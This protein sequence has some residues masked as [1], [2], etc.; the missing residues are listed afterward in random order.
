MNIEEIKQN[1]SV[2]M[3]KEENLGRCYN[4][5]YYQITSGVPLMDTHFNLMWKAGMIGYGQTWGF[6]R[7]QPTS[8]YDANGKP[9]YEYNTYSTVDSSD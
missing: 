7:D 3:I 6:V 4:K 8:F 1:V 5:Y 9:V 2:K